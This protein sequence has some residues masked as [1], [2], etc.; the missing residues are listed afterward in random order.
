MRNLLLAI[1][2]AVTLPLYG[3]AQDAS[4]KIE[5]AALQGSRI[6]EKQTEQ[7]V[8]RDYLHS[9]KTLST[10]LDTNQVTGLNTEFAG[11]AL[12]KLTNT[13]D[14]QAKAGIHTRYVERA[15]DL[16]I[17]FYS[18]E[19]LSIQMTDDVAYDEQVLEKDRVL[20]TQPVHRRYLI[21]MT[22]SEVRWRVRIFQAQA[23]TL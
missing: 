21:V 1:L 16:Q 8:V 13:I 9:W 12:D 4:V 14:A 20:T 18:P 5:P 22:P 7:S 3:V 23:G 10:A 6:L 17:I 11:T 2:C 15:H 19:G